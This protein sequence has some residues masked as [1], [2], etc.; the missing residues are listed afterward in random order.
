MI[1]SHNRYILQAEVTSV[2]EDKAYF[3]KHKFILQK[4]WN[5]FI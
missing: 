3:V 2:A 4:V 5:I 1:Y